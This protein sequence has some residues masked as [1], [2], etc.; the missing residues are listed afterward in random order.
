MTWTLCEFLDG[1]CPYLCTGTLIFVRQNSA[2]RLSYAQTRET[3]CDNRRR[4]PLPTTKDVGD[5]QGHLYGNRFAGQT[6]DDMLQAF[7][8]Y[9]I[10]GSRGWKRA[11]NHMERLRRL[12]RLLD[13]ASR[14]GVLS[15]GSRDYRVGEPNG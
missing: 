15:T 14:Y 7:R 1:L 10:A 2:T 3:L 5:L 6:Q 4:P 8:P 9:Q 12:W 11:A 13:F